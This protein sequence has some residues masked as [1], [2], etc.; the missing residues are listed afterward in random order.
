[1]S[2]SCVSPSD[3]T[4]FSFNTLQVVF[5]VS[6]HVCI[7]SCGGLC[8]AGRAGE[9]RPT[10]G[11]RV[12]CDHRVF[13]PPHCS[14]WPREPSLSVKKNRIIQDDSG[15]SLTSWQTGSVKGTDIA[16]VLHEFSFTINVKQWTDHFICFKAKQ[17]VQNV[18]SF[19]GTYYISDWLDSKK[20]Y[21]MPWYYHDS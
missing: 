3:N 7:S 5:S 9:V 19:F 17:N 11:P 8:T 13:C 15:S 14:R 2:I 16:Q 18:L 12:R 1:M 6:E 4:H 20:W 21:K 10:D